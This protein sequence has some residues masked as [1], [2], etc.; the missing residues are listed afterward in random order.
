M[1]APPRPALSTT[2]LPNGQLRLRALNLP[3]GAMMKLY[4]V[5][6]SHGFTFPARIVSTRA[7]TVDFDASG[8]R[9]IAVAYEQAFAFGPLAWVR[10]G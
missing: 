9:G 7:S 1:V 3:P 6:R 2:Q 10:V 5:T 8:I 4:G